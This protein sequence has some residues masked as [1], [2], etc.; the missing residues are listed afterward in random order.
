MRHT[1]T[2]VAVGAT[3]AVLVGS[4]CLSVAHSMP[5]RHVASA[6]TAAM[7]LTAVAAIAITM[8]TLALRRGQLRP[9]AAIT[10]GTSALVGMW[11]TAVVPQMS[12]RSEM[13]LWPSD[14]HGL[15]V[16]DID[17]DAWVVHESLGFRWPQPQLRLLPSEEIVNDTLA[18]AGPGWREMHHLWAFEAEGR[19]VTVVFDLTRI[20]SVNEEALRQLQEAV[21]G[22]LRARGYEANLSPVRM[23]G[24]CG[25]GS[26]GAQRA[27]GP[28]VD[29]R[30]FS[31]EESSSQRAFHLTVTVVGPAHAAG[32]AFVEGVQVPCGD[33]APAD[34]SA[35]GWSTGAAR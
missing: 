11:I 17:G 23:R 27:G 12:P 14:R 6:T 28:R 19:A 33:A 9:A 25:Y 32:A 8:A 15:Q 1:V 21:V 20:P 3:A 18:N 34:H 2:A 16:R 35:P 13:T 7:A 22:P 29:G 26:F 10:L 5:E 31:F 24:R 4:V 30:V